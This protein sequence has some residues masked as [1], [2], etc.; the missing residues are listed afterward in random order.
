MVF[1]VEKTVLTVIAL[2][3]HLTLVTGKLRLIKIL[4]H[5][6]KNDEQKDEEVS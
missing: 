1:L 2:D 5:C 4:G 6:Q 3:S